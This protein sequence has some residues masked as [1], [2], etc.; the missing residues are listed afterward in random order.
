VKGV[1]CICV[2]LDMDQGLGLGNS[3]DVSSYW[4]SVRKREDDGN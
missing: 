4:M 2:D 1:C 3:S